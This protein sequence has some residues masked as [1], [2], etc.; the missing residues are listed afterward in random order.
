MGQYVFRGCASNFSV[1]YTAGSTGFT[2]FTWYGYP[3][4]VCEVP[5][6]IN[7]ASF[8]A[9]PKAG[10]VIIQWSTEAEIDNAGFNIFRAKAEEGDYIKINSTLIAAEG[11]STQGATYEFIDSGLRNGKTYYY[12]L[13]DVGLNGTSTMHGLESATPRLFYWLRK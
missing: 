1:C 4:A 10:K 11:S 5:T 9:T 6:V 13:E 3:A 7:L 2:T 8:T 12:K